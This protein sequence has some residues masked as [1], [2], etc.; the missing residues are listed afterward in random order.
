M[1]KEQITEKAEA[2]KEDSSVLSGEIK[3]TWKENSSRSR[4]DYQKTTAR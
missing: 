3:V 4:T 2:S 1:G